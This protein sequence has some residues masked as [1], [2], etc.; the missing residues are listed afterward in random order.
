MKN[1]YKVFAVFG[2]ILIA[3]IVSIS[4]IIAAAPFKD[5][6]IKISTAYLKNFAQVIS[7]EGYVEPYRKQVIELDPAQKV[8]EVYVAEGQDV[9]KGDPIIKLDNSDNEYRLKVEEINLELARN[10]LKKLQNNEKTDK[11]ELEY[12]LKLAENALENAR[13]AL[14]KAK[15]KLSGD[16]KLYLSGA[17]SKQEYQESLD[18]LKAHENTVLLK[19]MEL[20]RAVHS[21]ENYEL[22]KQD[23][24]YE[25]N[26][27]IRLIE[28]TISNL[29]SKIDADTRANIDGKVVKLEVQKDE[30][31]NKE[32]SQILIYDMSKYLINVKVRQRDALHIKEDMKAKVKVKGL[33][34]KEYTGTIIDVEDV[35]FVSSDSKEA[36]VEIKIQIDNPD[37]M[38]KTGYLAEVEI[39][40]N[41]KPQAVVVN[42]E[43][44]VQDNDGNKY[45]YYVKDNM[46]TKV[47]VKTGIESSFEVEILE[48][49][50]Q[51]DKYIVNPPEDIQE[52]N[53]VKIWGWRYE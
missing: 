26:A 20:E 33:D 10:E 25:L 47:P 1:R 11:S 8:E 41:I 13:N 48:G 35:A 42:F 6:K 2:L 39:G 12:N 24:I 40:V 49:I 30:Y 7:A 23:K 3:L 14:E 34:A 28:E 21:F 16:E 43:S 18:S 15:T 45:I 46:A 29:K 32:N 17:I 44:I 27:K 31:P 9:K 53:S 19:Q 4:S 38:L 22:S 51:G 50:I 5:R 36:K 52:K 37:D